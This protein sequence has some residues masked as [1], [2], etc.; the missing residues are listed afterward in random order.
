MTTSK[1]QFYIL[2]VLKNCW[3]FPEQ[4]SA[5]A[6][7]T[8]SCY[9]T[10][11]CW[12]FIELVLT[13][14]VL[15]EQTGALLNDVNRHFHFQQA[16]WK[17][18]CWNFRFSSQISNS[19]RLPCWNGS[20]EWILSE[21]FLDLLCCSQCDGYSHDTLLSDLHHDD[22]IHHYLTSRPGDGKLWPAGC[23]PSW[24][25]LRSKNVG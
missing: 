12:P 1:V 4:D 22:L 7:H 24:Y 23:I 10:V 17:S 19:V 13:C 15:N 8:H 21:S 5:S 18:E 3:N 2:S 16:R 11:C 6:H 9:L 25:S 14:L 20:N